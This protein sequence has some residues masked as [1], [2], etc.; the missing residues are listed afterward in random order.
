MDESFALY[1]SFGVKKTAQ[2]FS[3]MATFQKKLTLQGHVILWA[4]D[5]MLHYIPS[6]TYLQHYCTIVSLAIVEYI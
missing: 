1:N 3:K 2:L 6:H 4:C 5:K